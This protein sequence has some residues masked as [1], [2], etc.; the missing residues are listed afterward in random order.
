MLAAFFYLGGV[1]VA[2]TVRIGDVLD[3]VC[4]TVS[5]ASVP[6]LRRGLP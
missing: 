4:N 3:C 2:L 5:Y 1:R 6:F